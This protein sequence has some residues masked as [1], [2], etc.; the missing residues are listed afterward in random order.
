[1]NE[2]LVNLSRK[3]VPSTR[4]TRKSNSTTFVQV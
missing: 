2:S 4:H 1:M 3:V